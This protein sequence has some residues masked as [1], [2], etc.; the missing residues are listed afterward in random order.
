MSRQKSNTSTDT[1]LFLLPSSL[2]VVLYFF[3]LVGSR[4][5]VVRSFPA[6][7]VCSEWVVGC[8]EVG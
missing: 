3:G 4:V 2:F 8:R 5:L 7:S 6:S 1:F